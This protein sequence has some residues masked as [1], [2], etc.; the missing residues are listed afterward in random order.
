MGRGIWG[1]MEGE[2]LGA[3]ISVERD[4]EGSRLGSGDHSKSENLLC[5]E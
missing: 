5:E 2:E 1:V 4:G 3:L